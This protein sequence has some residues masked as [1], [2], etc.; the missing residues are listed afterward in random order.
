V[1]RDMDLVRA[2]LIVLDDHPSGYAPHKIEIDGYSDEQIGYHIY[3][4]GQAGLLDVSDASSL[5]GLSPKAI[6][7]SLT[8]AGHE[9]L[10]SA[11]EQSNWLQAK[12]IIKGAG[13]GSF[14][15]WQAVLTK[16]VMSGLGL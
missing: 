2:I 7:H 13:E 14:Q 5:D 12:K 3:L 10:A 4:L 9:F 1:K 16:V 6:P 11:R 8:W 15:V